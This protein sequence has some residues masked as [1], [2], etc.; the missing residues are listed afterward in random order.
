MKKR[1]P[2]GFTLIELLAAASILVVL[3]A[4]LFQIVSLVSS[5]WRS[6][7]AR[8]DAFSQ[9]RTVL[10]ILNRDLQR[11]VLRPDL[12]AF[13]DKTGS[14]SALAFYTR[15]NGGEGDRAVSLVEYRLENPA[16]EPRLVR[17]DYGLDFAANS[18]R[19]ISFGENKA[20]P[21]LANVQ[22]RELAPGVVRIDWRFVDGLGDEHDRFVFDYDDPNATSNTRVM[23][24]SLLV[25]DTP[26]YDLLLQ[27]GGLSNL[28]ALTGGAANPKETRGEFWSRLLN[29]SALSNI[30]KPVA[31][32]LR[33]FERSISIPIAQ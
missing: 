14:V 8:V 1:A 9:A 11:M 13:A 18:P 19:T 28:L 6:G 27:T 16:T 25:L 32:S 2:S 26:S 7:R 21:D 23:R 20:L 17:C 31:R 3:A 22:P 10:E 33:V 5:S 30:P 29:T 15:A 12:A 24:I 4:V